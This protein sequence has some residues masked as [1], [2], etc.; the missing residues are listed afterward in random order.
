[1]ENAIQNVQGQFRDLKE[2]SESTHIRRVAGEYQVVP[3][4]VMQATSVINRGKEDSDG[5]RAYMGWMG[6]GFTRQVANWGGI[7]D[8]GGQ[9]QVRR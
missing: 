6:R 8:V 9:G 3:W 7:R 1:M 2:V 4:M 5:L